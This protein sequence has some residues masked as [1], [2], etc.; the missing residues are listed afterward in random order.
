MTGPQRQQLHTRDLWAT[1]DRLTKD[2]RQRLPRHIA[3][4]RAVVDWIDVPCLLTQLH[5]ARASSGS[6]GGGRASSGSR[7]PLD[8]GIETLLAEMSGYI[9]DALRAHDHKPRVQL[10][11]QAARIRHD[12]KADLRQLAQTITDTLDQDL[13]N[14]W[15]DQYRHWLH[16]AEEILTGDDENIDMRAVRGHACTAC[17]E[18]WVERVEPSNDPRAT[19]GLEHYRDPALVIAF[20]EGQVLHITCR[21]CGAGWWRGEDIDGLATA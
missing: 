6:G 16:R 9:V 3:G 7:S 18:T 17:F 2:T 10:N 1:A 20:R 12:L 19:D 13:V 15:T 8:L 14:W 5:E 4:S 11:H 21:A